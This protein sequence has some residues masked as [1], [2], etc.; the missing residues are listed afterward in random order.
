MGDQ[1]PGSRAISASKA[2]TANAFSL[3]DFALSTANLYW[4]A[5]PG[6][7]LYGLEVT[8][9]VATE[10]LYQGEAS[11]WGLQSDPLVGQR[12]GGTVVFGGGLPLYTPEGELVGG[13][14]LSGDQSC[15]DHVIAWK[16]RH[17]LN[18]DNVP[19]GVTEAENDNII[20]DLKQGTDTASKT[21]ASGYGHPECS[22]RAKQIAQDFS[23]T[24]PTGPEK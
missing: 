23:E 20:Y 16:V 5:Q 21:S 22:Q 15:T 4:P 19:D 10:V 18:L 24:F 11:S 9:P 8:N 1:W 2:F 14:G 7:S 3:P 12:M 6:N 13:I 17:H